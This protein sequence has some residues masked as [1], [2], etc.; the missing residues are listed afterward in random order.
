M[1]ESRQG[2]AQ[3]RI[4]RS[5][6]RTSIRLS[7][8]WRNLLLTLHV[9]VA[10]GVVG[11]D[12]VLLTL[13]VTGL[14]SGDA[15]LIRAGYLTMGLL[16]DTVLLPL[17][18][19]ALATGITLGLATHWGLTRHLWVLAKLVLTIGTA[20]AAVFVLRPALDRAAAHALAVPLTEL[21]SGAGGPIARAVI[22]APATALLV[23]ITTT[24]LAVVKPWGRTTF[25]RRN[26][27][28]SGD[29]VANGVIRSAAP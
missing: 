16:G 27:T 25:R 18:I 22:V 14:A 10:V 23:L 2:R 20:T 5:D 9:V 13:G 8:R 7:H 3:D 4:T 28:S 24:A 29:A 26:R 21:Q 19:G 15:D 1:T 11:L 6:I 12:V 17:A